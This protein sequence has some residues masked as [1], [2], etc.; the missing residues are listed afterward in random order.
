[1]GA[2][3]SSL[4]DE[5]KCNYIRGRTEAE[6]NNFSPHF[7]R[8]HSVAFF[9]QLQDEVE[10]QQTHLYTQLLK[11][12]EP[13]Q[14]SDL[15]YKDSV[16]HF[17]DSKKWK[18][19]CVTVR[20]DYSVELH[21]SQETFAKGTPARQILQLTGGTVLT[22]EEK[23]SALV[24]KAFPD[25]NSSKEEAAS[26]MMTV[27]GPFS[28]FLRL[29][30]RRDAYF[31]FQEE[32]KQ[33][34]FI[35][36]LSDCIRHQNHDTL[37]ES[38]CEVQAFLKAIHFYRQEKGHYESWEMLVGTD[39]QVLANLVMEELLP[40]LQ[41]E[42][43][44]KLKGKKA[45]RKRVWFTTVEAT[46]ELVQQQL[47]EGLQRL[48]KECSEIDKQ[49]ETLIRSDLDEI[50]NSRN[51]LKSKLQ[52]LVSEPAMKYCSESVSPYLASI[53]EELM[54]P[55]SSGFQAVRQRLETELNRICTD[56]QSGGNKEELTKALAEV[57]HVQLEDCYQHVSV[58]K[59]QLQEL[60][61]R[62]R[63]SNSTLV[64]HKT[65]SYMQQLMEN[66]VYTFEL[67]LQSAIKD[68]PEKLVTVMEKA[69]L[70]M[71]K[72]YDYD[73]S[74]VRK[75]IFHEALVDITFPAIRRNL[76]PSCKT[77]LQHYEQYIFADYTNFIQ[78]EN[79]YEDI[80]LNILN[81]EVNKVVKEAATLKKHNLFVDSTELQCLS[82]SSLTDSRTPPRSA[83]SS[84]AV[85]QSAVAAQKAEQ[86]SSS[87]I[88]ENGSSQKQSVEEKQELA[89][90]LSQTAEAQ[91]S[92]P[93][94]HSACASVDSPDQ[95]KI[96]SQPLS[97]SSAG[98]CDISVDKPD[99]VS[100][101]SLPEEADAT[102]QTQAL[103]STVND[104]KTSP[105]II[106]SEPDSNVD[107]TISV[108]VP[109][110]VNTENPV[111]PAS[112]QE[113]QS[114]SALEETKVESA[115]QC[116]SEICDA[117]LA[118]T[119]EPQS[120]TVQPDTTEAENNSGP[121]TKDTED[122]QIETHFCESSSTKD[123]TAVTET[124]A[125]SIME[126]SS[127]TNTN[128]LPIIPDPPAEG[129]SDMTAHSDEVVSEGTTAPHRDSVSEDEEAE[130]A[131]DSVKCI[132]DLV[133]EII[134]V[135]DIVNPCP[136]SRETQ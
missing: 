125:E 13:P 18:E 57:S 38:T 87:S 96:P 15:V 115:N 91:P 67:L 121:Q 122:T 131:L 4:L 62:F 14:A 71:L 102:A 61:S 70:R 34:R 54:G 49:Q 39:C 123:D 112:V 12:K 104:F 22:S 132:R 90:E 40:S 51:F 109:I 95:S 74:T 126:S 128:G 133:V 45:E 44:P 26:P 33:I 52:G 46:Y 63:F 24:D 28:V 58:L 50:I 99:I 117:V 75:R 55:V 20:A 111:L 106:V 103:I 10:Q 82:Q 76:A 120:G 94:E 1:M 119:E 31:S 66:A 89:N 65:Q 8:Q 3:S 41:T 85:V 97:D 83:P 116:H 36:I 108:N 81:N 118:T 47:N 124:P 92:K 56:F 101:T 29:P 93:S 59:E 42:L 86:I 114:V 32:D 135:E 30:Y 64:V 110:E 127:S 2:S 43:L 69:K 35:S 77:E 78:V 17:D 136:D 48:K 7:K 113:N 25:L 73:S 27:P 80:M 130:A 134:E 79:V 23:Y 5:T 98:N 100:C 9:S 19:R 11:Q 16:L 37:K 84:P 68:E 107:Q 6:L 21:D 60:R 53:L 88:V 105:V 129:E 72:Q